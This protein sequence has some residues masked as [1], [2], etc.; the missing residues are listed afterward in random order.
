[1]PKIFLVEDDAVLRAECTRLLTLDG[2]EVRQCCHFAEAA[3]EALAAHADCVI[4]D[5]KLPGT[6][7]LSVCRSIRAKSMVP[8]IIL[9]SSDNEFDE[10]MGMNIGADDYILKPYSPAILLARIRSVLRRANPQAQQVL[11]YRGVRLDLLRSRASYEG[12]TAELARNELRIL[13]ALMRAR[14]AIVSRADLM[15]ELWQSDEFVDD[16]TLTVNVNRLRKSLAALGVPKDFLVTHRGQGY[17][18]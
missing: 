14:G 10:V 11:E 6:D 3:N 12:R 4:L 2:F 15:Y 5:L 16:N 17:S 13:A 18:I 7:G 8:I 1:M 9:T